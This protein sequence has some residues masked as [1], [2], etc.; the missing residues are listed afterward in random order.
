MDNLVNTVLFVIDSE[1]SQNIL[2]KVIPDFFTHITEVIKDERDVTDVFDE[3]TLIE[4]RIDELNKSS[5]DKVLSLKYRHV[6]TDLEYIND[7]VLESKR[8]RLFNKYNEAL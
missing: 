7:I 6:L 3:F 4:N 8:K 1:K 5:E 2:S